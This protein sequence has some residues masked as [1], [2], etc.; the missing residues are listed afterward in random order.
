[1]TAPLL[2]H[3]LGLSDRAVVTNVP[4]VGSPQAGRGRCPPHG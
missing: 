1:M 4:K 2:E 3:A